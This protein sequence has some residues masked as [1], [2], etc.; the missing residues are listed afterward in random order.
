[1]DKKVVSKVINLKNISES[2]YEKYEVRET[3]RAVV[4]DS[5]NKMALIYTSM[6][7][8]YQIVGG[9]IEQGESIEEGLK[10][11][12][13]EEA[14]V[15]IEILSKLCDVTEIKD[16]EKQVMNSYCFVARVV[17][18]KGKASFTESELEKGGFES[19]WMEFEEAFRVIKEKGFSNQMGE[20]AYI[21]NMTIL[22]EFGK[23]KGEFFG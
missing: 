2:E 16:F 13:R 10:R 14:G 6:W 21:R 4:L 18:E 19:V 1:M 20:Y 5:E 22:G 15:E 3:A 17:G 8:Y 11:E 12:C 9:G 7:G 23:V